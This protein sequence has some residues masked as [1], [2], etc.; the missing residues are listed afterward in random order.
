MKETCELRFIPVTQQNID[1]LVELARRIWVEYFTGIITAG[2]VEYMLQ[3]FQSKQAI[4][5][6]LNNTYEYF[7]VQAHS[8]VGYIG[9]KPEPEKEKLFISK[10][11][12]E[13]SARGRGYSRA[14]LGFIE[15][16]AKHYSL[17]SLYLTVNRDNDLAIGVYEHLGFLKTGEQLAPIGN[18]FVMDDFIF[19]KQV[20]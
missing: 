17:S 1:I 6:Q 8:S 20:L 19:E 4:T 9:I 10:F 16:Q 11:Y 12:L 18:G 3:K 2:Q 13:N 7:L 5:E 15:E 14:M